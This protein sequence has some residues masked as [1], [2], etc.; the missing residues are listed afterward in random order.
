VI[1]FKV[2]DEVAG[3]IGVL[4]SVMDQGPQDIFIIRFGTREILLPVSDEIILKADR[5]NKTLHVKAPEGLLAIYL[6]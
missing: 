1:G 4:E 2:I 5:K 3:P 6:E